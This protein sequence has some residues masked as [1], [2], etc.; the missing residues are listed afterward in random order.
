MK[1]RRFIA[2]PFACAAYFS[3][4][5]R[6]TRP[7]TLAIVSTGL[8]LKGLS[9]QGPWAGLFDELRR[10]GYAEGETL[11]VRRYIAGGGT[12]R[13]IE[14]AHEIVHSNPDCILGIGLRTTRAL[15]AATSKIP[16]VSY[17]VDPIVGG[18]VEDLARPGGNITGFI[19][20]AGPQIIGKTLE[21]LLQAVPRVRRVAYLL[22]QFSNN[23]FPAPSLPIVLFG[24]V[25]GN[26]STEADYR[27]FFVDAADRQAD[28]IV[29][30]D[31]SENRDLLELI[32]S[33]IR[34]AHLPAIYPSS[35]FVKG[36]GLMSYGPDE[37]TR[38]TD[39]GGYVVRIFRGEA[40]GSMPFQQT[41]KFEVAINLATARQLGIDFPPL[42]LA[43]A[44]IVLE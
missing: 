5:A 20:D 13:L 3:L 24:S 1:R 34:E 39:L 26:L 28:A 29:V 32:V 18:L 10:Q 4:T 21:T 2:A 43:R 38:A 9:H 16:I 31:T 27:R 8:S 37:S 6:A 12:D 14:I 23:R 30:G 11:T 42:V 25:D 44:S 33:L 35:Q 22:P 15:K 17:T 41:S 7:R 19:A 40:P 36:G